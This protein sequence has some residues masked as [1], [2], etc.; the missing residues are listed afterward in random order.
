MLPLL[1]FH[2]L[3]LTLTVA[4]TWCVCESVC[5]L[6]GTSRKS[7]YKL[8]GSH[9]T[10]PGKLIHTPGICIPL[11]NQIAVLYNLPRI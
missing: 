10:H 7:G 11:A 8:S 4:K 3:K 2:F 1:F 5:A 6:A 9:Y